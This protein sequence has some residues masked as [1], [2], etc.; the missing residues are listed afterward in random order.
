MAF[1]A[2]VLAFYGRHAEL[3]PYHIIMC[4]NRFNRMSVEKR[5]FHRSRLW[6]FDIFLLSVPTLTVFVHNCPPANTATQIGNPFIHPF[7]HLHTHS[8]FYIQLTFALFRSIISTIIM[9]NM[10]Y[11]YLYDT[12]RYYH[13]S[14]R[15]SPPAVAHHLI[16]RKRDCLFPS[17]QLS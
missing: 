9:V 7:L 3:H 10:I 2:I 5:H 17:L 1:R 6:S 11:S 8:Y 13:Y 16:R 14:P 4:S 12:N 15:A